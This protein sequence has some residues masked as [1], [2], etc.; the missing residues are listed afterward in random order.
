MS[1][2][3]VSANLIAYLWFCFALSRSL[4]RMAA[5]S[6][7]KEIS[8]VSEVCC[9]T[10]REQKI[11]LRYICIWLVQIYIPCLFFLP[12]LVQHISIV[13]SGSDG[14]GNVVDL[15]VAGTQIIVVMVSVA[16]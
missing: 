5:F 2:P 11:C 1:L 7:L 16:G 14:V 4:S 9:M 8:R 15:V 12:L 13:L 6:G 3:I 10:I